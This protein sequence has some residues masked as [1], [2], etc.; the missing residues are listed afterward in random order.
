ML[1]DLITYSVPIF[2]AAM[3]T[4]AVKYPAAYVQLLTMALTLPALFFAA[5][6]VYEAGQMSMLS[7]LGPLVPV[8][9]YGE[10]DAV[11]D[12]RFK[13]ETRWLFIAG[14][15]ATYLIAIKDLHKILGIAPRT[16]GDAS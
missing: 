8:E 13:L 6:I 15:A 9:R 7:D 12:A 3:T 4:A 10:I 11:L 5:M 1:E 16:G 14:F 2:L